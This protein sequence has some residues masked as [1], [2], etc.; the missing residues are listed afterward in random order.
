MSNGKGQGDSRYSSPLA[1]RAVALALILAS[2]IFL[3][4][5]Y[6]D[7]DSAV[8]DLGSLFTLFGSLVGA[9]FGIKVSSDANDK[10]RA[11]VNR[12]HDTEKKA[13]AKLQPDQAEQV[14]R[15]SP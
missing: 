13:L 15:D 3:V 2:V 1:F 9:Y 6:A 11:D 4:V 7:P 14:L 10:S 5:L 12:S 8:A